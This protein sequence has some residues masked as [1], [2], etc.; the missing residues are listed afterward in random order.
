M[1]KVWIIS[2]GGWKQRRRWYDVGVMESEK[3]ETRRLMQIRGVKGYGEGNNWSSVVNHKQY[4]RAWQCVGIVEAIHKFSILSHIIATRHAQYLGLWPH[5][6]EPPT[7]WTFSAL[8]TGGHYPDNV[9]HP[10]PPLLYHPIVL[11]KVM[12]MEKQYFNLCAD[13]R[14]TEILLL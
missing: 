12:W 14:I 13:L 1:L 3:N 4:G 11:Q 2:M 7:D 10:P 6:F 8:F 5:E 9:S